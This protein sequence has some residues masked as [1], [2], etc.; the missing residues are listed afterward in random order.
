MQRLGWMLC[1]VL[2]LSGA[3]SAQSKPSSTPP[4]KP[5]TLPPIVLGLHADMSS[6]SAMSGEAIRRG[7][8][9]ALSELN[10]QGGLLGGRKL[11]L[12]VRD[13]HG[14]PARATDQL[15]ELASTPNL[16][17]VLTGNHSAPFIQNFGFILGH[18]LIIM[19]PWAA[20][21][22]LIDNGLKPNYVFRVSARDEAVGRF[23]VQKA[24]ERGHKKLGLLLEKTA[25]GRSTEKALREALASHQQAAVAVEWFN[26]AEED[27]EPQLAAL[28]SAGAQAV[29][30][31]ANAPEGALIV[32]AMAR[33][34]PDKRLPIYSH[35]G[36]TAGNLPQL[37]GP[38]LAQVELHVL[39]TFF[40]VGTR[41][42][43][44]QAFIARYH[45]TFGTKR[46]EDISA[47]TGT[48]QAYDAVWLLALAIEK[49]QTTDRPKVRDALEQLGPH[50]GLL[51]TYRPAF[52]ASRHEALDLSD[53]KLATF[54]PEG[55]L[56]PS[57]P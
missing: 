50:R 9:L 54:T 53:Y 38:S 31:A 22:E 49:A 52:T 3:A 51:R 19:S 17:A 36:I 57:Q 48:T 28:E 26:W 37:A 35:S 7:A 42:A 30:I 43:R 25:W 39:Q 41:D 4:P 2:L 14:V 29:L 40:F 8:L 23:L 47:P 6:G 1:V 24:F 18:Q 33:R 46:A 11:Q 12:V 20:S 5:P 55:V 10:A 32:K 27:M 34:P 13:H 15:Q 56:V 45:E 21:T 16:V 44:A